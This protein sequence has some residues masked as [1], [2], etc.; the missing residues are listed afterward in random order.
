M[1]ADRTAHGGRVQFP[2]KMGL[3]EEAVVALD[4]FVKC[5]VPPA[6][7][8]FIVRLILWFGSSIEGMVD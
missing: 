6:P 1:C 2:A 4:H 3:V 8:P 5:N 7:T